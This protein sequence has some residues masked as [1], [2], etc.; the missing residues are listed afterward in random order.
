LVEAE[1]GPQVMFAAPGAHMTAA[2]AKRPAGYTLVRG[3]SF[4]SPIVAGLL[5]LELHVVDKTAADASIAALVREAIKLGSPVPNPIYGYG[6][7][8]EELRRQPALRADNK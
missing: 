7:V 8:G 1:R 5:S 2:A 3:T 4:A 6:L